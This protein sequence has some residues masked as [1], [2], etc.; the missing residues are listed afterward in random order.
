MRCRDA[1]PALVELGLG[2]LDPATEAALRAHLELC[3]RCAAEARAEGPLRAAVRALHEEYPLEI[4]VRSRVLHGLADPGTPD[5]TEV[6]VRQLGWAAACAAACLVALV[7]GLRLLLPELPPLWN[8]TAGLVSTFGGALEG[9]VRAMFAL[10]A[11]PLKLFGV[12]VRL[13]G[14]FGSLLARLEPVAVVAVA[15]GY[16]AMSGTAALVL[17]RDLRRPL[18]ALQGK[19]HER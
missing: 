18:I 2:L 17:A 12:L 13:L 11:L 14:A 5:L 4:D 9:L 3:P 7:A 15:L 10:L 8:E 16:A 1:G 6:S 19:E